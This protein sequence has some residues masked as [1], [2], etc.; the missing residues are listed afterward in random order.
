M[1]NE[2]EILKIAKLA[3]TEISDQEIKK[4]SKQLTEII[5]YF[6][7]LDEVDTT[8][9]EPTSHPIDNVK[10]RFQE[11]ETD[12]TLDVSDVLKNAKQTKKNYIAT[13]GVFK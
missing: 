8:D 3:K 5:S 2:E 12:R 11:F 4:F 7:K 6:K 9:V 1:I 10:N 13:K